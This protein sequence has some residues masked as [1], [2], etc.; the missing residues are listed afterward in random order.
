MPRMTHALPPLTK[1]LIDAFA[2]SAVAWAVGLLGVHARLAAPHKSR[3]FHAFVEQL[4]RAVESIL[5]LTAVH[6]FGPPPPRRSIPRAAPPGFRRQLHTR[7]R[8]FFRNSGVRARKAGLVQRLGRLIAV[9]A[10]PECYVAYFSKRLRRPPR[11]PLRRRTR[12]PSPTPHS[13]ARSRRALARSSS[14]V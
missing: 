2:A 1:D 10:A 12:S 14:K 4:E 6:R 7:M 3:R 5:F 13:R 9:M 8:L 11:S